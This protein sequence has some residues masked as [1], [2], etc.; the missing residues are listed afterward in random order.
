MTNHQGYAVWWDETNDYTGREF[1]SHRYFNTLYGAQRFASTLAGAKVTERTLLSDEQIDYANRSFV[2]KLNND[3]LARLMLQ[4]NFVI[5]A[6]DFP[7]WRPTQRVTGN[8]PGVWEFV[9]LIATDGLLG[10]FLNDKKEAIVGHTHMFTGKVEPLFSVQTDKTKT[11]V[12]K[13]RTKSKR[14]QLIDSL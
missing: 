12:K 4:F 10:M 3:E 11:K 1:K 9:E 6:K 2:Q 7:N 5:R 13:K 14:Q 8:I